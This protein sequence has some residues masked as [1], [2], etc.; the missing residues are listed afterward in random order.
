MGKYFKNTKINFYYISDKKI[1][2]DQNINYMKIS[3]STIALHG[4]VVLIESLL[5]FVVGQLCTNFVIS[6]AFKAF[7]NV[8][9]SVYNS[10]HL[11]HHYFLS[12]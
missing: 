10:S 2:I 11:T 1:K 3:P 7:V 4:S 5:T 6:F 12:N 9:G 8:V